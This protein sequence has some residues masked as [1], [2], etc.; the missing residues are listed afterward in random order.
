[1]TALLHDIKYGFRML[2]KNPGVTTVVLVT[3]AVS[4][5]LNTVIFNIVG[6]ARRV[7]QRFTD[8]DRLVLLWEATPNNQRGRVSCLDYSDWCQQ[9][10]SFSDIALY[11]RG[12]GILCDGNG[13]EKVMVIET[14][15]NFLPML[16]LNAQLGRFHTVDEDSPGTEQVVVISDDLWQRRFTAEASVLGQ[17]ILLDDK[18]YVIVGVLPPEAATKSLWRAAD[19]VVPLSVATSELT[20]EMRQYRSVARLQTGVTIEQAQAEMKAI[21][22]GLAQT[23]PQTNTDVDVW[24][25]P[26]AEFLSRPGGRLIDALILIAVGLVLLIACVNVAGLQLARVAT[27]SKEFAMRSTLGANRFQIVRQLLLENVVLGLTAG[28]L[29]LL[30]AKWA[31]SVLLA[32]VHNL[33]YPP[34]ELDLNAGAVIYTLCLSLV[35]AIF[36]GLCQ[37]LKA[38]KLSIVQSIKEGGRSASQ[39]RRSNR[40]RQGLV[41]VQLAVAVPLLVCCGMLFRYVRSQQ[42]IDLGFNENRLLTMKLELPKFRYA[43]DIQCSSF[44]QEAI[45]RIRTLPGIKAAGA[46]LGLEA[47][48]GRSLEAR[49][50]VDSPAHNSGVYSCRVVTS[51]Y[52]DTMEIPLLKG[53]FFKVNDL[54]GS[55]SVAIINQRMAETYWADEDPVGKRF[56]VEIRNSSPEWVTIVGVVADVGCSHK[57]GPPDSELY[58][59]YAQQPVPNLIVTA[60]VDG[61]P[62]DKIALIQN[63]IRSIDSNVP[64]YDFQAFDALKRNWLRDERMAVW[65]LGTLAILA[66]SLSNIGLYGAISYSVAQRTHELGVRMALGAT[67]EGILGLVIKRCLLLA[68]LG[69]LIGFLLSLPAGMLL[70]SM[71]HNANAVDVLTYII[72]IVV[73]LIVASTAGYLPARR[74]AR[75]DPMEALRYE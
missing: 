26:L 58:V 25:Q 65:F 69:L 45:Y 32:L 40:L 72:V 12:S 71:L 35:V 66:F 3:L 13:A 67:S 27:R 64:V 10:K 4:I 14:T 46:T 47:F 50:T 29:S 51:D 9:S 24:V 43:N 44:V 17:S 2:K 18:P 41:L 52:F 49:V 39:G 70:A 34:H 15:A 5:G 62:M 23:Y 33:P 73:F 31:L 30:V 60:R 6:A 68:A 74:A 59:P 57:G 61:E 48:N 36:F 20:R 16:G 56:S 63:T 54:T 53:R 7:S 42:S 38:T 55:P 75:I 28:V 11:G 21:A 19:V 1:M 8:P 22:V 37:A